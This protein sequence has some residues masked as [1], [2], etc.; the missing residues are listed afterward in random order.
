M[1]FLQNTVIYLKG[2]NAGVYVTFLVHKVCYDN[3]VRSDNYESYA[4]DEGTG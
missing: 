4:E 1:P 2:N 3:G